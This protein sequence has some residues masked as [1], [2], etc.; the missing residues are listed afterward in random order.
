M[1][2][3]LVSSNITDW[4]LTLY[5]P[6]LNGGSSITAVPVISAIDIQGSA[7][8]AS[9]SELSFDYNAGGSSSFT[10]FFDSFIAY[11]FLFTNLSVHTEVIGPGVNAG[12]HAESI[13]SNGVSVFASVINGAS[14]P[15]AAIPLPAALPLFGTALAG[16]GFI[17]W[18]RRR[19]A[20]A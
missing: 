9:Q 19:K 6:D 12:G 16:M 10:F 11:W 4:E 5:S 15:V 2:G 17:G 13:F 18:R 1:I 3:V 8:V 14:A 7:S 20:A